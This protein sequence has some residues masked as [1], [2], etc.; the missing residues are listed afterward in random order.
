MGFDPSSVPQPGGLG[1]PGM[2]ERAEQLREALTVDSKPGA[3]T[4]VT[5]VVPR[6]AEQQEVPQ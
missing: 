4:R 5:A 3:G 1:L 2:V 6:E